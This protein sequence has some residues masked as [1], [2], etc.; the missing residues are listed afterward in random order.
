VNLLCDT[1]NVV[2]AEEVIRLRE[3]LQYVAVRCRVNRLWLGG[4]F[5]FER[6]RGELHMPIY[7]EDKFTILFQG[8]TLPKKLNIL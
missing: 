6:K 1:F 8:F 5:C 3:I 2:Y 4:V 7:M